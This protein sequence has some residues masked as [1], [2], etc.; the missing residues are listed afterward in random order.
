MEPQLAVEVER[1]LQVIR[2]RYPDR[3]DDEALKGIRSSVER[4]V[5]AG[6]AL[7]ACDLPNDVG[8]HF[9]PRG[10]SRA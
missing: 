5:T 3:F 8:P 6:E 2:E 10:M 9:D 7:R 1:R 4:S